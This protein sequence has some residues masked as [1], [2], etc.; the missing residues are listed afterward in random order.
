MRYLDEN[1]DAEGEG[2]QCND[3]EIDIIDDLTRVCGGTLDELLWLPG[4]A[5]ETFPTADAPFTATNVSFELAVCRSLVAMTVKTCVVS[6]GVFV[7]GF[8]LAFVVAW[9]FLVTVCVALPGVCI[10]GR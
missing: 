1:I 10:A 2:K 8:T 5:G 4:W 3:G 7:I 9:G 6:A